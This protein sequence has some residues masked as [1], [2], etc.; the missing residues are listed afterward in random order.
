M[1]K[2]SREKKLKRSGSPAGDRIGP[3]EKGNPLIWKKLIIGG[4]ILALFTPL[5]YFKDLFFPYVSGKSLYFMAVS[6]AVF[7]TWL[8]AAIFYPQF[9]PRKNAVLAALAVF[10]ASMSLSTLFGVDPSRSFWSNYERSTGLLMWLHLFAFFLAVSSTLKKKDWPVVF[11]FSSLAAVLTSISALSSPGDAALN[12]GTMGNDSFLGSYLIFNA[13]LSLY[14]FFFK[15]EDRSDALRKGIKAFA[16]IC[17][18][19]MVFCLLFEDSN[20]WNA[21]IRGQQDYKFSLQG[22][23]PDILTKGARAAKYSLFGGLLLLLPLYFIIKK[24]S[25]KRFLGIAFLASACVGFL[26][27][28]FLVFQPGNPVQEKFAQLATKGRL[29]VWELS[30]SSFLEK[31]LLGW[32]PENFEIAFP[33]HFDP[34]LFLKEYGGEARFDR[35]HNIIVDN[36]VTLGALGSI[37]YLVLFGIVLWMLGRLYLSRKADFFMAALPAAALAAYFVQNLTVFDTVSSLL[38]FFLILSYAASLDGEGRT[39]CAEKEGKAKHPVLLAQIVLAVFVFSFFKFVIYPLQGN[40]LAMQ[41]IRSVDIDEKIDFCGKA[42][43][44]SPVGRYQI[45]KCSEDSFQDLLS[46][47]D[48][49]ITLGQFNSGLEFF[50]NETKESIKRVPSDF[51][52]RLDLAQYYALWSNLDASKA[53]EAEKAFEAAMN[54][55]PKHQFVYWKLAELKVSLG[56]FAEANDLADKAIKLEPR[57]K[58][59]YLAALK[60]A[61]AAGDQ[62]LVD[63]MI[64]KLEQI[65]A[66]GREGE[67]NVSGAGE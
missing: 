22:L 35:A 15:F 36:F 7:F 5:I 66:E 21:F 53:G 31:P 45:I 67:K 59:S 44:A 40:T 17:F 38:M 60:A 11:A 37:S 1:G 55:S 24:E 26:I 19:V 20:F 56:K 41:S 28:A 8:I 6:E 30:L 3:K 54:I 34:R 14:L 33:S 13:F 52:S 12:R 9:R 18:A 51:Y 27:M 65:D 58:D 50:T 25:K 61:Q 10:L 2:R 46:S 4:T 32:G 43:A 64:D 48:S 57:L 29:V 23:V 39:A 47:S 62:A 63:K 16:I 42:L 49:S